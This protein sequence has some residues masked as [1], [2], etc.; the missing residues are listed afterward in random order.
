MGILGGHE[1]SCGFL[2]DV[3][4][5]GNYDE[6]AWM[7]LATEWYR[8]GQHTTGRAD[9]HTANDARAVGQGGL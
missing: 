6:P 1:N 7:R 4:S 2:G 8:P 9:H 5:G 3:D